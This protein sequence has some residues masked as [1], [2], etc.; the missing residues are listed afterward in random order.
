MIS[1]ALKSAAEARSRSSKRITSVHLKHAVAKDEQFDFLSDI[2]TKISD[3]PGGH[4]ERKPKDDS[5]DSD[6]DTGAAGKKRRNA[7]RKRKGDDS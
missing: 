4:K 2:V 5:D 7:G 1:L 3:Q 6:I